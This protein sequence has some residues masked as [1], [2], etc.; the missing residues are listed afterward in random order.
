MRPR[1]RAWIVAIA[2]ALGIVVTTN[3][4]AWQLRRAAQKEALAQAMRERAALPALTMPAARGDDAGA[5]AQWHRPIELRGRWLA[6]HTVYLDNRQMRGPVGFE[7]VTPL[8]LQDGSAV[9][10]VRGWLPRDFVDRQ[11]LSDVPTPDDRDVLVAGRYA[12]P[13][14]RLFE[15]KSETQGLGRV[16][17]NLDLDAYAEEIGTKLR[18]G[19]VVQ[20]EQDEASKVLSRAWSMPDSGV[21]KHHGY[22]FQ[23]FGLGALIAGLYVWFQLIAPRRAR[24]H[25]LHDA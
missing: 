2:T 11:R 24:K 21:A 10:V 25:D 1:R 20:L 6:A 9:A 22:A 5:A 16:R 17:Q 8:R 14:P 3:L 4:G 23:W 18:P 13:P 19:S 7:V 12:P 15:F